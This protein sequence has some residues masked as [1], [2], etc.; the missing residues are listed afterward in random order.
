MQNGTYEYKNACLGSVT[1]ET[2]GLQGG[3]AGHGGYLLIRFA[4]ERGSTALEVDVNGTQ[5]GN[6]D[7]VS[8]KFRGDAEIGSAI[9][10]LE[11]LVDQLREVGRQ[12][13]A[14]YKKR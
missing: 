13:S 7:T 5:L 14:S 10:C 8:L 12:E 1:Y 2:N 4:T 3:D 6:V 11:Y 9:E